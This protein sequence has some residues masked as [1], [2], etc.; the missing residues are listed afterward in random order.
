MKYLILLLAIWANIPIV[1]AQTEKV[2]VKTIAT[3]NSTNAIIDLPGEVA[4]NEWE[5]NTIRVTTYLNVPNMSENIVKQ[6]LIVGRYTL[7][8]TTDETTQTVTITMPKMKGQVTVKGVQ[9][10]ELLRF[11]VNV[12]AGYQINIKTDD[13][14]VEAAY[15]QGQ[16]M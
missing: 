13:L 9:L 3:T 10:V 8:A 11:E 4:V 16:A 15:S 5:E 6:L 12:P 14:P 7:E 1:Q 2:L